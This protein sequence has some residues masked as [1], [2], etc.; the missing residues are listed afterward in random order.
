MIQRKA[1]R[2]GLSLV[3]LLLAVGASGCATLFR[4]SP[5][6]VVKID[7]EP[8]GARVTVD[9][10]E[11]GETPL[12]VPLSRRRAA[13]GLRLE[14]DGCLAEDH[15]LRRSTS[16]WALVS[17]LY[18]TAAGAGEALEDGVR[19]LPVGLAMVL[20]TD[21]WSG[22]LFR[23]PR[24]VYVPLTPDLGN[25][26]ATARGCVGARKPIDGSV[27]R[28]VLRSW[29]TLPLVGRGKQESTVGLSSLAP[30]GRGRTAGS[31]DR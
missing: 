18:G 10:E 1:A 3:V 30:S 20:A 21:W 25:E 6:S 31:R 12:R 22:A 14:L 16:W 7:S 9:G 5:T 27:A 28:R 15:E 17:V 2:V 24:R 13:Y 11:V 26:A 19:A 8:S 29:V 4:L 23:L